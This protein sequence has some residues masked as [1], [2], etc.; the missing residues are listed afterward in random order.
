MA[1]ERHVHDFVLRDEHRARSAVE[2]DGA[3]LAVQDGCLA[4]GGR[5][6]VEGHE[7]ARRRN[8]ERKVLVRE[9]FEVGQPKHVLVR[10]LVGASMTGIVHDECSLLLILLHEFLHLGIAVA[11]R[12]GLA[13]EGIPHHFPDQIAGMV[14]GS[15]VGCIVHV[16]HVHIIITVVAHEHEGVLP[17]AGITVLG[18][19]DDLVHHHLRVVLGCHGESS[20]SGIGQAGRP[21]NGIAA[22]GEGLAVVQQAEELVG[23]VAVGFAERVLALVAQ[24]VVVNRGRAPVVG[25]HAVVPRAVAE[26]QQ[27]AWLVGLARG[28]VVQH[29]HISL[30]GGGIGRAAREFVVDFVGGHDSHPQAVLLAVECCQALGLRAQFLRGGNDDHHVHG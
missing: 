24:Q 3:T 7:V 11:R 28:T 30:V 18:I 20:H 13:R 15:F 9:S 4:D 25:Q 27:V 10:H 22:G 8:P 6:T 29:F 12:R 21:L 19:A 26:Q 5:R 14:L 23:H 16:A 1:H 17:G 2:G